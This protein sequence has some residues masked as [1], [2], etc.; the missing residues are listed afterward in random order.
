MVASIDHAADRDA[1]ARI[2]RVEPEWRGLATAR[3]AIRLDRPVLLHAGPPIADPQHMA[4]P[5]MN[6]AAIAAVYEGWAQSLDQAEAM[7]RARELRLEPAQ[8]YGVVAPLAAVVSPSML[9]QVVA[10]RNDPARVAWSPINGGSGPA[11]RLGLREMKVLDHVHWLNGPLAEVLRR[12]LTRPVPLLPIADH[13]LSQG[14][15]CHG[16]TAAGTRELVARL[17]PDFGDDEAAA[18]ARAFLDASPSFFLN[19][20][21]AA[22]KC[23]MMAAQGIAGTSV[24]TA[25]GGNGVEFGIGVGGLPGRWFMVPA[26]PPRGAL[27]ADRT[28]ASSLGAIGDSA[29]VDTMG[30]GAMAL[31]CAPE[32][33]KAL[34]GFLPFDALQLPDTLLGAAHPGLAKTKRAVGLAARTVLSA[35]KTPIVSLGI[36]DKSGREGRVGGGVYRPP[37]SVFAAACRALDDT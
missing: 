33:A 11:M 19:L 27:P 5:I 9:L 6:S 28:D 15:D 10:D 3:Q 7:I 17:A 20:W 16:R 25:S 37:L 13:A 26:E 8:D 32:T 36:L 31:S 18:R 1:L 30:M 34:A 22:I 35:N 23:M 29:V 21:M 4:A 14:D 12:G 2:L 24:I